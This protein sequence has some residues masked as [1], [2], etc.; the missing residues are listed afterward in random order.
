MPLVKEE[1][2][3]FTTA[4][5]L[6]TTPG[7]VAAWRVVF[8]PFP[9]TATRRHLIRAKGTF[10]GACELLDGTLV[11]K[12]RDHMK[13][14]IVAEIAHH[15]GKHPATD[16]LGYLYGSG[17]W[18]GLA[19][20]IVR[21]PDLCFT[22]WPRPARKRVSLEQITPHCPDVVVEVVTP[23]NTR[24]ELRRKLSDYF[25]A[26][27]RLMWVIDPRKFTAAV[28]SAP[29]VKTELTAAGVLDG[30][31]VL[32]GF[33]LPLA[34]LFERLEKPGTPPKRKRK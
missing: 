14:Y 31:D 32:P 18:V 30:G 2:R 5:D 10:G 20:G 16:D 19:P 22:P 8:D 11:E 27:V 34:K 17:G 4:A 7:G 28:Y 25:A 12:P 15:L 13:A 23:K 33:R 9:G 24:S 3:T 6:L 21:S 1:A 29:D 26:G